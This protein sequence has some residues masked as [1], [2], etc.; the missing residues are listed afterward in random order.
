[1][2]ENKFSIIPDD[3][4]KELTSKVYD[5]VAHSGLKE[6]GDMV[7][8]IMSFVALPFTFLGM[9]AN[10]LKKKY[11]SFISSA[12]NK[13]SK[14]DYIEPSSEK[15]GLL[16]DQAKFSFNHEEMCS[17]FE[18][19]L[20]SFCD[21]SFSYM[22]HP[23]Y[24]HILSQ[25][26]PNDAHVLKL[27]TAKREIPCIDIIYKSSL[28]N[29]TIVVANEYYLPASDEDERKKNQLS[30]CLL[31]ELNIISQN[32]SEKIQLFYGGDGY[33]ELIESEYIIQETKRL[34]NSLT[35][36]LIKETNHKI[37][38]N[39]EIDKYSLSFTDV[40]LQFIKCCIRDAVIGTPF[41][42]QEKNIFIEY[43]KKM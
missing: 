8:N 16:L 9:T 2:S 10:E 39:I 40:G 7:G 15:I 31:R 25:L 34:N 21:K 13:V 19:L 23:Y 14:K 3:A 22:V 26:S 4:V 28:G 17:M 18:D 27:L 11:Q 29:M 33:T 43:L 37:D 41:T 38:F 1:M 32:K 42:E 30:L 20:A 12:L 5:D 24:I 6:A 36:P 35:M